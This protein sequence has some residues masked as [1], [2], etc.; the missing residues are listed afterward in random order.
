MMNAARMFYWLAM[1]VVVASGSVI[2]QAP[3]TGTFSGVI[4]FQGPIPK[5]PPLVKQN[6]PYAKNAAVC[7]AKAIPDESLA[8]DR[9]SR[10]IANVF[11]YLRKRPETYTEAESNVAKKPL[12]L[13]Q[14]GCRLQPHAFV[15]RNTDRV[16]LVNQNEI[17]HNMHTYP[18]KNS[19]VGYIPLPDKNGDVYLQEFDSPE[20]LPIQIRCDIHAWM[21]AWVLPLD[22]PFADVTNTDGQFKIEGLPPGV[23]DFR[24]WHER[25]G[26]LERKF[27]VEIEAGETTK[28]NLNYS[29]KD[30]EE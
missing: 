24:I 8:I 6:A 27:N 29:G 26:W 7:A 23:Y 30:F 21:K 5:L 28:T 19:A 16:K 14:T 22:H 12:V 17:P 15:M 20:P 4:R 2:A 10:G 25:A 13:D 11:V 3:Q 1:V 9:K 18:I